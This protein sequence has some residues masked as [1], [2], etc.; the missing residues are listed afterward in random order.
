MKWF[1]LTAIAS[2]GA[3]VVVF[4]LLLPTLG[5]D[6]DPPE[7]YSMFGYVVPCGPGPEQSQSMGFALGG[8]LLAG[9]LVGVGSA[10]G[11]KESVGG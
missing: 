7:C 1:K 4:A 11:R 10:V 3:A 8:A 6:T 2:L 9:A 5:H